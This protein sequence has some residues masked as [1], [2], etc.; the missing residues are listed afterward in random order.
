MDVLLRLHRRNAFA[1]L[2]AGAVSILARAAMGQGITF[3]SAGARYGFSMGD[4]NG[5]SQ[6]E[7]FVD[8]NLPWKWDL[9][10]DWMLQTR[11]DLSGGSLWH[12]HDNAAVGTVGP[13]LAW[14]SAHFPVWMEGGSSPTLVSRDGFGPGGQTDSRDFGCAFQFTTHIGIYWDIVKKV[15]V[16][17]RFQHMSNA[18]LAGSNPGLNLNV[19]YVSYLF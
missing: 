13:V 1:L 12:D 11:L 9:G 16:G 4:P 10:K 2:L 17:Y 14:G 19:F 6:A 3:E 18:H 5:Y 7:A 8:W 15:R